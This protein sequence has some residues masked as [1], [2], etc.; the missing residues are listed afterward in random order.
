VKK[1]LIVAD[2]PGW[3]FDRHA[4]EIQK[5]LTEYDIQVAYRRQNIYELSKQFDLVYVMDPIP[6]RQYPPKEKTILGLR[7]QF[8]YEEHPEGPG[9]LYYNGFPGRCVSI[10]D[11]CCI[12][13]VVNVN[14][15][16][17][18]RPVVKDKPL[19]LAQHGVDTSIFCHNFNKVYNGDDVRV[20]LSGRATANKGFGEVKRVCDDMGLKVI[21]ATYRR[22]LSKEE[23]PS[24][25]QKANVHV[26]FSAS[27][28]LN[29]VIMEAGAIGLAPIATRTGAAEEMIKDGFSGLLI[30]RKEDSLRNALETMKDPE[31][32]KAMAEQFCLTIHTSWSWDVRIKDFRD[33]FELYFVEVS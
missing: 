9:G 6:L 14:Q 16:E 30:D 23:M 17:S 32:R 5:R 8:L 18:F 2:E 33:M 27:E 21:A 26:C 4:H 1:I 7:C 24:F 22:R 19:V 25:Y 11:K 28:G 31:A 15:F 29:N 13:H 10:R 12:F 20:S 3:I